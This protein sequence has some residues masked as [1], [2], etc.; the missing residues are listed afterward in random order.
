METVDEC[1]IDNAKTRDKVY[2]ERQRE[3]GG[4]G[5]KGQAKCCIVNNI[6]KNRKR[7]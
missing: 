7:R 4:R 1:N 3:G 6:K 2:V 5:G